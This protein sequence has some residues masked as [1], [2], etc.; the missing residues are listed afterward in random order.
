MSDREE[1]LARLRSAQEVEAKATKGPWEVSALADHGGWML[2]VHLDNYQ[3]QQRVI[4]SRSDWPTRAEMSNANAALI[5]ASRNAWP[6]VLA[7]AEYMLSYEPSGAMDTLAQIPA[8]KYLDS[9]LRRY[10][11]RLPKRGVRSR[12]L[13]CM[14]FHCW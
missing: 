11:P 3:D 8:M 4:C 12:C 9:I 14:T 7:M 10:P 1:L 5:V 2:G 13:A 6:L